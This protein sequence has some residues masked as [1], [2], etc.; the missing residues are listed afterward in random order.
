MLEVQNLSQTGTDSSLDWPDFMP[1]GVNTLKSGAIV[2][3]HG[4]TWL[5]GSSVDFKKSNSCRSH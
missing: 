2:M 5:A 3:R 1:M 4:M